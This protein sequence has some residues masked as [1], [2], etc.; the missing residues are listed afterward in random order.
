VYD[1]KKDKPL[2]VSKR[3]ASIGGGA[4]NGDSFHPAL[5]ASGR[6]A[7]YVTDATN[8]GGPTVMADQQAYRFDVLGP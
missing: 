1:R 4:A 6:Y 7:A 2:L 8:L 3:S 5:S